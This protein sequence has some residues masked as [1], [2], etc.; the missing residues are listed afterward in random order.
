MMDL[1]SLN[2]LSKFNIAVLIS[3]GGSN[4]QAIID[5]IENKQLN[6]HIGVVISDQVDAYGITRAQTAK[7]THHLVKAK[8]K[9]TREQ[10]DARLTFLLEAQPVDLIVLAGFMRILSAAFTKHFSRKIINL[11][12]SL[13]PKYKGLN[14]H[15]RAIDNQER[16][17]GASVHFVT[18]G[19]DEG[20]VIIQEKVA[21]DSNESAQTLQIKVHAIEH[22]ILPK[23]IKWLSEGRVSI[24]DN[25]VVIT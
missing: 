11:H 17:H 13:L 21:I 18:A 16:Y 23:A 6:A 24:N 5:Q 10:Y 9:E 4:L 12:P 22:R 19:L 25:A 3:G 20:P 2:T 8:P 1:R 7:I 15:A 14:T